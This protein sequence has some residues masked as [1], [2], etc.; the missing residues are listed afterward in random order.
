MEDEVR[1]TAQGGAEQA[2]AFAGPS[3]EACMICQQ[4]R[5]E[6]LHICGEFICVECERE[7]INTDVR[8]AKYPFFIHQMKQ[9]W[10]R[11]NA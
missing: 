6:G 9:V 5:P 2:P 1:I 4:Q 7:M 3:G 10:Q 11:K 8:D